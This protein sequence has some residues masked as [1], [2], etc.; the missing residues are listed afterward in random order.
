MKFRFK[1]QQYQTDTVESVVLPT[2]RSRVA[3]TAVSSLLKNAVRPSTKHSM[4]TKA[5]QDYVFTDGTAEDS[6]ERRFV[7]SLDG[8]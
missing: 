2:T 3:M 1:I 4:L 8:S 7:K 6:V 5:I